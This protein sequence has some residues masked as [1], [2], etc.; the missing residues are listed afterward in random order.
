MRMRNAGTEASPGLSR[1]LRAAF[2]TRQNALR[3]SGAR[4]LRLACVDVYVKPRSSV[5]A[6][7]QALA[8]LDEVLAS[9]QVETATPHDLLPAS[10]TL[11]V[12]LHC[13]HESR[14]ALT[15]SVFPRRRA[16]RR[17]PAWRCCSNRARS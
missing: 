4:S 5:E 10:V 17:T 13:A 15:T 7:R 3:G 14:K 2:L 1:L 6:K 12:S 11:Q 9:A 16:C 8:A